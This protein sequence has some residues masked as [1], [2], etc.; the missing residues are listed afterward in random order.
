MAWIPDGTFVMGGDPHA[1]DSFPKHG[2]TLSGFWLDE[3]EVTNA[4]FAAFV[5]D[6]GYRTVAERT[7]SADELPGVAPTKLA[8]G[9]VCFHA[10]G[11][12]VRLDEPLA[13][14]RYIPGAS[15]R[16]PEGSGSSLDGR[17]AHPVVHVA[18]DDAV[19]Y[20]RHLGRRLPTEAEWEY[21]ARGGRSGLRFPWGDEPTIAGRWQANVWQGPFPSHNTA[22][23]GYVGTSPVRSFPANGYGLFDMA[24]NVWEWCSDWYRP[25]AYE[26]HERMNPRGPASGFDPE[27]PMVPKRVLRGGSFLCS[28]QY[29]YRFTNAARNKGAPDTGASHVGFRCARDP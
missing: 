5:R 2:V 14:W 7:P 6:T 1:P 22:D 23:D 16:H 28:E 11:Q 15:W 8:P 9:S 29:C 13:W 26:S 10:T 27:E 12:H 18:W 25:D 21:A 4:A 19:A 20:C 17:D 24:G 3:T